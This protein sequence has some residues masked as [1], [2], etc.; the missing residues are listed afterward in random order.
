MTVQDD[1]TRQIEAWIGQDAFVELVARFDGT[2]TTDCSLTERLSKLE[3]FSSVWDMRGGKH[4]LD[5]EQLDLE[6]EAE[7]RISTLISDLGFRSAG[8]PKLASYDWILVLGGLANSCRSRTEFT[9]DELRSG[10]LRVANGVALLGSFRP[11]HDNEQEVADQL[12]P[13]LTDEA[14]CLMA[15][16]DRYF[17]GTGTWSSDVDMDPS[18]DPHRSQA[19]H[20]ANASGIN[21]TLLA[22]RSS[23]PGERYANTG[24]TYQFF[25]NEC[26]PKPGETALLV[27]SAIYRQ[28]QGF[29]AIRMLGIPAQLQVETIGFTPITEPAHFT[30]AWYLQEVRSTIRSARM[31]AETIE[32]TA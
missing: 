8:V 25:A 13:G 20:R 23:A 16:A 7:A 11:L 3:D 14:S 27:T 2:V 17:D 4:R 1:A 5:M 12:A 18:G 26:R 9:A 15:A 29:D 28:Y 6:P 22:A 21:L 31:L 10:D 32:A 19:V 30:T 24:D